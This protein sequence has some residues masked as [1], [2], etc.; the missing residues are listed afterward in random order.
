MIYEFLTDKTIGLLTNCLNDLTT[1]WSSSYPVNFKLIEYIL[2]ENEIKRFIFGYQGNT[3]SFYLSKSDIIGLDFSG[4]KQFYTAA[5]Q[6]FSHYTGNSTNN[7]EI[8]NIKKHLISTIR[9]FK[10]NQII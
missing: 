5:F 7:D 8:N 4:N 6:S 1:H 10:L 2:L 9:D 3:F